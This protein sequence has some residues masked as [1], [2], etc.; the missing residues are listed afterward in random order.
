[1]QAPSE[2]LLFPPG[3]R[4]CGFVSLAPWRQPRLEPF[5][6]EIVGHVQPRL[7]GWARSLLI[8]PL[9]SASLSHPTEGSERRRR[10]PSLVQKEGMVPAACWRMNY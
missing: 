8:V 1:M 2:I 4:Q 5:S 10:Q 3:S 7:G 6:Q 9:L